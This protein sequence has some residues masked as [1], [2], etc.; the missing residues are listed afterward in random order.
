MARSGSR[1]I[2]RDLFCSGE[3]G[4]IVESSW[5][6]EMVPGEL[7]PS[8]GA[9]A[10][11]ASGVCAARRLDA[12]CMTLS[13]FGVVLR[14]DRRRFDV[15]RDSMM[16]GEWETVLRLTLTLGVGISG[17]SCSIAAN[18]SAPVTE[19]DIGTSMSSSAVSMACRV[20]GDAG[21]ASS[22]PLRRRALEPAWPVVC[23][24]AKGYINSRHTFQNDGFW[25][26]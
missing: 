22:D 7:E 5:K 14:V 15:M 11:G 17:S 1:W 3:E 23:V 25:D 4:A 20:L 16:S 24:I 13:A 10:K 21:Y 26:Y 6:S 18:M 19:S 8:P 2:S 9:R 12:A